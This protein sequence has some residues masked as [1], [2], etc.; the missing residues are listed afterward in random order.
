M[1]QNAPVLRDI[2]VPEVSMWWPLAPGWWV[3]IA[4]ALIA[5]A[6]AIHAW[7]R[8]VARRRRA[9]AVLAELHAASERHAVDGDAAAFAASVNQLLR[10]VARLRDPRSVTL[11]GDAWA[12]ALAAQAP[13]ADVALLV[14]LDAAMYR[15]R[16]DID[17][18]GTCRDADAWIRAALRRSS[19]VTA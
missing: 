9:D 18:A 17:V 11:S 7:R 5:V 2:H 14:A 3:L 19:R 6:I 1:P 4:L 12:R 16:A 13:R 15:P 8:R 10:R